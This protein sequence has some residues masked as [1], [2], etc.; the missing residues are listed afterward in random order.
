MTGRYL[1]FLILI[2]ILSFSC[3]KRT[4]DP[5]DDGDNNGPEPPLV[6]QVGSD[7]TFEIA[8]WNI[9]RFPKSDDARVT[10]VALQKMIEQLD[11]DLIAVEEIVGTSSFN[12]MINEMDGW[13]GVLNNY[14]SSLRTGIIYK[15]QLFSVSNV[16]YILEQYKYDFARRPPFAAY[17]ELRDSNNNTILDFN[18]IV[19]HLKAFDDGADRRRK[20]IEYLEK[21]VSDEIAAGSDPDFIILGDWN[22][23]LDDPSNQ[24]VFTAFKDNPTNYRFLTSSILNDY[25]YIGESYQSLIDHIMIT[26]GLSGKYG[27]GKTEALK[28]EQ[29]Y[30]N[31]ISV[32]SDHRPVVSIFKG[33]SIN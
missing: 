13:E 1:S 5:G 19:V 7:E 2:L 4:T 30:V 3:S 32:I 25:S 17:V 33:F 18:I 11:V 9:E 14:S 16:R 28:L 8:T 26:T 12:T 6:E 29:Q 10:R 31:Y 24:N 23:L 21:Y 15:S 27:Q 20:S 22:D